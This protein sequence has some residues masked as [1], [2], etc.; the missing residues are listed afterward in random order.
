MYCTASQTLETD[1]AL[2]PSF[3]FLH[4]FLGWYL[5]FITAS[6]PSLP[7]HKDM[8]SPR[9]MQH[10]LVL[11]P[12]YFELKV[13]TGL[14]RCRIVY[15]EN[16]QYTLVPHIFCFC[17]LGH[18]HAWFRNHSSNFCSQ[19]WPTWVTVKPGG[20]RQYADIHIYLRLGI[21]WPISQ[22]RVLSVCCAWRLRGDG[23]L[24]VNR[25][26]VSS[27]GAS[28]LPEELQNWEGSAVFSVTGQVVD[29]LGLLALS[30]WKLFRPNTELCK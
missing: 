11:K 18:L 21:H 15:S 20:Q 2:P 1:S 13:L 16:L 26:G 8:M 4:W 5:C 29:I 30:L 6:K 22:L 19:Y 27:Q 24:T 23:V 10:D 3:P 9:G 25:D 17:A 28:S 14:D 12:N 7:V